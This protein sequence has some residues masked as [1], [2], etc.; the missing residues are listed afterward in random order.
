MPYVNAATDVKRAE[1]AADPDDLIYRP[2]LLGW[3]EDRPL[4]EDGEQCSHCG[5]IGSH[6]VLYINMV[7]T[8]QIIADFLTSESPEE[9]G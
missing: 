2:H 1:T 6:E 3:G 4:S 9:A 7:E 8:T 5:A